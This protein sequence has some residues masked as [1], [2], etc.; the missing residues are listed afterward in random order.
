ML[1]VPVLSTPLQKMPCVV[2]LCTH[3]S[4]CSPQ[5]RRAARCSRADGLDDVSIVFPRQAPPIRMQWR[6]C[7]VSVVADTALWSVAE[8]PAHIKRHRSAGARVPSPVPD[9]NGM[10]LPLGMDDFPVHLPRARNIASLVLRGLFLSLAPPLKQSI[11]ATAGV[12][13]AART[14]GR[15]N[16]EGCVRVLLFLSE[17]TLRGRPLLTDHQRCS[18]FRFSFA[19]KHQF[20]NDCVKQSDVDALQIT[21]EDLQQGAVVCCAAVWR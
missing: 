3:V 16:F 21:A 14:S 4:L 7:V 17:L 13:P 10:Q 2:I 5:C 1:R 8:Q 19:N 6:A 11:L 12:A 15:Y 20:A 18:L 9:I